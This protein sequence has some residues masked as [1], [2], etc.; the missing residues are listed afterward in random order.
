MRTRTLPEEIKE[1]L[2][3]RRS[4]LTPGQVGLPLDGGV[5]RVPGLRREEVATL[6][7]ISVE[8][9]VLLERGNLS[10]ASE[11]VLAGLGR[12]LQLD[13]DEQMYL[14]HLARASRNPAP[15]APVSAPQPRVSGRVREILEG[16][17][18]GPAWV[19]NEYMDILATNELARAL[20]EPIYR[21]IPDRP[22]TARH[23][24]LA[25][26]AGEFWVDADYYAEAFA[27]KLRLESAT[28]PGD[29]RLESLVKELHERSGS[30]RSHWA[31]AEVS[32]F[33]N[34]IKRFHHPRAGRLDLH[35]ETMELNSS[36]GQV[37]SF[38]LPQDAAT[39][40]G[41]AVLR[42]D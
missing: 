1:F 9:Y 26:G 32:L 33:R 18:A 38:Y 19:R 13:D 12:A 22:N 29:P 10:T 41:L 42:G 20:Y 40:A 23:L 31:S 14:H 35:F 16:F 15:H 37:L 7:G 34:G 28:S 39:A 3:T 36:P 5:R 11:Q 4:R 2:T 8:Y 17:R 24:Y 30:F 25:P 6:A 27:A 21:T